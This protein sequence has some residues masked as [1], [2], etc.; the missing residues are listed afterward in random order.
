M[1]KQKKNNIIKILTIFLLVI[2]LSGC[3]KTLTDKNNKPV[4]SSET[5]RSMTE[6]IVCKPTAAETIKIYEKNGVKIDKL[7]ECNKMSITGKYEDLWNSFFVRPLAF[8]IIKIGNFV[9][10]IGLG[11]IIVT[12][13]IRLVLYPV[14]RKTAVQSELIKEAQPELN[15]LEKKY[16]GKTDAE[17]M[18]K[19]SQEMMLIY[20][21]YN[22]NPLSGCLFSFIQLPLLLAFLEAIN[23]V[24]AIFEGTFI[25]LKMGMTPFKAISI[26]KYYYII[27]CI[28]IILTTYLSFKMNK[29][30]ASKELEQNNR[31]MMLFM[32]VFIGIMSFSLPT[33]IAI[34]WITSSVFTII[35]NFITDRS[36]KKNA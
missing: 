18:N 9:G 22:I 27:L 15:K 10:N 4:K 29:S 3:T 8:I 30:T 13:L 14:T 26:G 35:Q 34:Y 19:K 25:G 1:K 31:I 6:N 16:E 17:S 23:R 5:G 20:K 36:K 32:T 7:P 24:P 28:L 11:L 21:K 2:T 33:A 12:L